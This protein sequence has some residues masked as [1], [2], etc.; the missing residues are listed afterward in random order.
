MFLLV[1]IYKYT[2]PVPPYQ[3]RNI[4]DKEVDNPVDI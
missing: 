1:L 4:S 2:L 3:E